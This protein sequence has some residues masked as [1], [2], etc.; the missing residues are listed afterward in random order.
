MTD[1]LTK[2]EMLIQNMSSEMLNNIENGGS[3]VSK[4]RF[5]FGK[6]WN[7]YIKTLNEEKIKEAEQS[8]TE[9]LGIDSLQKM[10]FLDIGSGSGLF[11]LAARRLGAIVHSFDYDE[12]SVACT[13]TLRNKYY[14][15]T[16]QWTI[17]RGD[18][19][20]REYLNKYSKHDIVYSWGVLH[21]TGNMH[22][23]LD[24]AGNLVA[25]NGFLFIAIYNDQGAIS[26]FWTLVKKAYNR[27]VGPLKLL[28]LIPYIFAW[29]ILRA[30]EGIACIKSKEQRR[31]YKKKRGMSPLYDAI[32]WCGGYPFEVAKPEDILDFYKDRNFELLKM[33]TCGG[34][35]GCNQYLFK[36]KGFDK[37]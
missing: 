18:I 2:R 24:N 34:R 26:T 31:T 23:A 5:G 12:D 7:N 15:Q 4:E 13:K 14:P 11:S 3:I 30:L 19:L 22:K 6:N 29:Y 27:M 20:D 33:S 9:W 36:K 8:L 32:D 1:I 17:E 37:G 16:D 35:K 21:H 10:T 25:D 28:I